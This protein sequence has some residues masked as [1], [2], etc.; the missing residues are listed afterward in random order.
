MKITV[1]ETKTKKVLRTLQDNAALNERLAKYNFAKKE[2]FTVNTASGVELNACMVKP[3]NF[4]EID[5]L[6]PD[7]NPAFEFCQAQSFMVY[8]D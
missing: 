4:D 6:R 1:N 3:L 2:F 7:K 8:R 5:T